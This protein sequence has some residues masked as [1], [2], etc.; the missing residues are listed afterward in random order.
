MYRNLFI[1]VLLSGFIISCGPRVI[2]EYQGSSP[3]A[4]TPS[5]L[6]S[7]SQNLSQDKEQQP[8]YVIVHSIPFLEGG[9]RA[10]RKQIDYPKEAIDNEI[11]GTV[12][13]LFTINKDG[14]TTNFE[15]IT[16][17]GF[18]CEEA[19]IKAIQESTFQPGQG[20]NQT[21]ARYTWLVSVEFKL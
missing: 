20:N 18:G 2:V 3:I 21:A 14:S 15:P 12:S 17:I 19:V 7:T 11:E 16:E 1:F 10:L 5:D 6:D 13:V 8:E 4:R 9:N